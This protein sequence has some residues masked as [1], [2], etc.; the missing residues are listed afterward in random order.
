[1]TGT[2]IRHL[3]IIPDGNRRWARA[4]GM[5]AQEGHIAGIGAIDGAI[6]EAFAQ[7]VEMVTFW[8]GSPANLTQR[9][10]EEVRGIVDALGDWLDGPAQRLLRDT[11]ARFGAFGRIDELCPELRPK[12]DRALGAASAGPRQV[13]LLMGYDGRDELREA[14]RT[15]AR[16]AS[17]SLEEG[18][19]TAGL[20][21]V[22]LLLRSGGSAHL[23][24]GFMLWH[25]AEARLAFVD[26]PWPAVTPAVVRR[27]LEAAG[28]QTRRYG[29]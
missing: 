22:D 7:G 24:A 17:Q 28:A 14:A 15:F 9:A 12:L 13:T 6:R 4:R 5:S 16:G 27:E 29:R 19:W 8:W 1:M 21:D 18:L 11:D 25:I 20:P 10:P 3:A 26:E 2:P 23:S